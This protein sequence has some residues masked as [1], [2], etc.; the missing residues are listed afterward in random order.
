MEKCSFYIPVTRVGFLCKELHAQELNVYSFWWNPSGNQC[1]EPFSPPGVLLPGHFLYPVWHSERM[2]CGNWQYARLS[3]GK[4][5][6]TNSWVNPLEPLYCV[7]KQSV[8]ATAQIGWIWNQLSRLWNQVDP[9]LCKLVFDNAWRWTLGCV[10]WFL[11][12]PE[13]GPW[14]V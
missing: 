12:M 4:H 2:Q 8:L 13:G 7:H 11:T 5:W 14:A 3:L 10:N 9:G 6:I 1:R